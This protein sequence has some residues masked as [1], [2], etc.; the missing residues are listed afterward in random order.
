M[1]DEQFLL[2][3]PN[4]LVVICKDSHTLHIKSGSKSTTNSQLQ[5]QISPRI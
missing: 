4:G 2:S 3:T 1:Q 5:S